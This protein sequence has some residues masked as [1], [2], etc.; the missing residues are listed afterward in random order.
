LPQKILAPFAGWSSPLAEIPDE[1]FARAM[2]GEGVALDPI[3]GEL[4]APCDGEVISVA[5]A[6]HAVALRAANGAEILVHVGIDTVALGGEGFEPR[7]RKGDRVR[8][9]DLLLRFDLELLGRK[10]RSLITPV[11]VTNGERFRVGG[12]R[13]DRRVAVGDVL[14]EIEETAAPPG[15]VAGETRAAV[16]SEAVVIT[17]AHGLHARPA[18][19]IARVAKTLPYDLEI[20][21]RGRGANPKSAVALMSLGIRGGDEVVIAGFE[22]AAAAGVA[23]VARTIRH[24]DPPA[25]AHA[26]PTPASTAGSAAREGGV[27]AS[28]GFVVG[29]VYRFDLDEIAVSESGAGA[30]QEAAALERALEAVRARIAQR[31]RDANPAVRD[32]MTAHLELLEDPQLLAATRAAVR[33]GKSAGFAWRASLR[34]SAAQLAATGDARLAERAADLADLERQVLGELTGATSQRPGIPAG[35]I[36]VA[37]DLTPSQ[38]ID[39]DTARLGGIALAAGGP[40]SHVAI[41]AATLGVPMMVSLGSPLDAVPNGA[42]IILDAESGSWRGAP[43]AA[44]LERARARLDEAGERRARELAAAGE[45]CHLASGERIE[46]FAN[47]AGTPADTRRALEQGAEGCGLLRTEFLFLDRATA[48][49]EAEQRAS[50]QQVADLL[51]SRPLV[52]RTLDIGGDKPIAYLPLPPEENPALG[53]RG[54]R[55]SLWRPDLLDVQLRALLAVKPAVRV[56]LP[57]IT[58]VSEVAHVRERLAALAREAGV[59]EPLL[60]AMIETPAAAMLADQV[61]AAVDF[62][63]IGTNDLSQYALAMDR[64]HAELAARIDGVHPAVLRLIEATTR[65]AAA[66]G[67]P[68][69]VCGGLASDPEAV[70]LLLGLGVTELSVVPGQIPRLKSLIRTLELDACR[71]LA[72]RA[73]RLSTAAEVRALTRSSS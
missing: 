40:T 71:M 49:D 35:A 63:S 20:R 58:D 26:R 33:G 25:A 56:L 31:A 42:T 5:A 1:V 3:G 69:A 45:E 65:G 28:R 19:L 23:E 37:R 36:L 39:L 12:A 10:A 11:I 46:V 57:M 38:L 61:A 73:L 9:G 54:I 4:L 8:A 18:A 30:A 32:I 44:E 53:L 29:P 34:A 70:P 6:R 52:I 67:T 16:I 24:L 13:V 22:A 62:L 51:G 14:F 47:L 7:V 43:D 72:Q 15:D 21:A 2:L 17:H 50:Y 60:G 55:T 68:V 48:P 41:L 64:G 59:A 27:I 66:H